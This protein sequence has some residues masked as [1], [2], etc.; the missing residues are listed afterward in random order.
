M[1]HINPLHA[2]IYPIQHSGYSSLSGAMPA[3]AP[4]PSG[5]KRLPQEPYTPA[6]KW[7]NSTGRSNPVEA[8]IYFDYKGYKRQGVSMR[9]LSARSV[10]GLFAM[11]EGGSDTVLA[12]TGLSRIT[13]RIKAG[14]FLVFLGYESANWARSIEI[15]TG[16][17]ITRAGLAQAVAQNFARFIEMCRGA[18]SSSP[19]WSIAPN[20]IR[21]E[22]LYLVSLFNVFEDSWQADVVVDLR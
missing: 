14:L 11:L 17:P 20:N 6:S 15:N 5:R 22:H 19:Q 12:H 2:P 21:Y 13:F 9:E 7:H 16:G 4:L 1:A 18:K 8:A 10:P 3:Q